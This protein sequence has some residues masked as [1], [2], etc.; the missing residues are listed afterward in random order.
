[1][2]HSPSLRLDLKP[3]PLLAGALVAIHV[4]ALAAAGAALG[5]WALLLVA[6][7]I[8]LSCAATVAQAL[9]RA[10]GAT[11]ALELHADGRGAWC[12]RGGRWH[13]AT[14][15]RQRFVMPGLVILALEGGTQ[16]RKWIVLAPDA[17]DGDSLRRLRAWLRWRADAAPDHAAEA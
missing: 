14:L 16:R 15:L 2:S 3:S 7:G 10:G 9:Q 1:M 5:G 11:R 13:V 4:L 6:T 12:D 8:A 17:S